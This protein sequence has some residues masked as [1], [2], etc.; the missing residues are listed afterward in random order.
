M[1]RKIESYLLAWKDSPHRK[2]LLLRGA[3]QVGKSYLIRNFAQEHFPSFVEINLELHPQVHSFFESANPYDIIRN[4]SV[5]F[6]KPINKDTLIFFDEI[7]ECPKAISALRYFYELA[8]ELSVI[9]AGS[10]VDFV[11]DSPRTQVPV[12]R[13]QYLFLYPMNFEE[14]LS[15]LSEDILIEFIR[16]YKLKDRVEQ[17]IHQKLLNLYK[18]YLYF[19]G[20][21]EIVSKYIKSQNY[22]EVKRNQIALLQTYRDDFGKYANLPRHK[23][24]QKVFS[25]APGLIGKNLKYSAIDK[26]TPSREIKDALSM[27]IQAGVIQKI[28]A[29]TTP[30]LP[31]SFSIKENH[32]KVNFLDIGLVVR[33]MFL[34]YPN[35]NADNH[36]NVYS[37]ILTEQFVTQEILTLHD[38]FEKP[39]YYFWKRDKKGS[40]AEVDLLFQFQSSIIPIEIKSGKTGSLKSLQIYKK[41]YNPRLSLRYSEHPLSF[42]DQILSIP[43]Y[44]IS[45][46]NRLIQSL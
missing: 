20:M 29:V 26:D 35:I 44:M 31:L 10:L 34:D 36:L 16:N 21:P 38:P 9:S 18:D 42:Y 25:K 12:G 17:A 41:E 27:L 24:L 45:E 7:Q 3:R 43:L 4:F 5:Y 30:N 14:Y 28:Q 8:P 33:S 22:S 13:I 2:P 32:F 39:E 46:T 1:R 15:A 23:Y 6:N 11:L 40:S 19:G 37:G